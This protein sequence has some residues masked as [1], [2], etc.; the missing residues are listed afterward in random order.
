ME[1]ADSDDGFLESR[2]IYESP[3]GWIPPPLGQDPRARRGFGSEAELDSG[4]TRRD[5]GGAG[6]IVVVD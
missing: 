4:A 2:P 1:A 3:T 6:V 5:G